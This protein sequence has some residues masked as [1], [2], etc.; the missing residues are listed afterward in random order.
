[1]YP[2]FETAF[3]LTW[4]NCQTF[5]KRMKSTTSTARVTFLGT[6]CGLEP[7]S[8]L[9]CRKL[10]SSYLPKNRAIQKNSTI[11]NPFLGSFLTF[12]IGDEI[13]GIRSHLNRYC[14]KIPHFPSILLK[15][16]LSS[17][18]VICFLSMC[19]FSLLP[20]SIKMSD[21][22]QILTTPLR[23]IFLCASA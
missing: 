14:Q 15:A 1:M 13:T 16:H 2:P 20:T 18:K 7:F 21:R 12:I 6:A 11:I 5:Q 10:H 19:P 3:S 17:L 22:S 23:D 4:G 9:L 8:G